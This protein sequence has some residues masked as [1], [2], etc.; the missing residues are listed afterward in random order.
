MK[1]GRIVIIVL[2]VVLVLALVLGGVWMMVQKDREA[3][4]VAAAEAAQQEAYDRYAALMAQIEDASLTVTEQGKQIGVYDLE[5]LGLLSQA[6]TDAENQFGAADKMDPAEFA[7]LTSDE[8]IAWQ[9]SAVRTEPKVTLHTAQLDC[10]VVLADLAKEFR[11]APKDAYAYFENGAY[12]IAPEVAGTQLNLAAVE[13]ALMESFIG[14]VPGQLTF[15][16]ADCDA[17][18]PAAVTAAEGVFDYASLLVRDAEG[19]TI[20]V[21]LLDQKR[22]LQV[23]DLVYADENGVVPTI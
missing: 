19:V 4:A 9:E 1:K 7:A 2:A 15:E 20:T 10:G 11:H 6:R 8:K 21:E 16:V 5:Q 18:L 17:Y 22:T 12:A 3:K 23:A 14:A 13:Q